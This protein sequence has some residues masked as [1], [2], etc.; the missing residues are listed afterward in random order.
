MPPHDS[1][2]RSRAT[3]RRKVTSH[4][5]FLVRQTPDGLHRDV[6]DPRH[7]RP[8]DEHEHPLRCAVGRQPLT[9]ETDDAQREPGCGERQPCRAHRPALLGGEFGARRGVLTQE[10]AE[11]AKQATDVAAA[12]VAGEA[13]RLD[14][15]I[16]GRVGKAG[17]ED[18]E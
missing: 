9:A 8:G 17:L 10:G 18:V 5:P 7:E 12:D 14:E 4:D 2:E 11:G 13:Q 6:R 3:P 1:R 16:G 15:P